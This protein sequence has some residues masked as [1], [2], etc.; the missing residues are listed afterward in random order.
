MLQQ[1]VKLNDGLRLSF[2]EAEKSR[3]ELTKKVNELEEENQDLRERLEMLESIV[4]TENPI[5]S[6]ARIQT[7][8]QIQIPERIQ[9]PVRIQTPKQKSRSNR[10]SR[11]LVLPNSRKHEESSKMKISPHK[12]PSC[13]SIPTKQLSIE[14]KYIQAVNELQSSSTKNN[15]VN[16]YFNFHRKNSLIHSMDYIRQVYGGEIGNT[17]KKKQSKRYNFV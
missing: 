10:L 4:A 9:S 8:E 17:L 12:S 3:L 13:S 5:Q 2:D 11:S 6:P 14:E 16:E 1:L 15:F 7:P